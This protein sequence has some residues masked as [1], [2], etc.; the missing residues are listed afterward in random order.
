MAGGQN[1]LGQLDTVEVMN[2]ETL[3]WST[4][5]SLPYPYSYASATLCGEQ[6]YMLGGFQAGDTITK[7]V[8]T[9]SLPSLLQSCSETSSGQVWHGIADVPMYLST[10][11]AINGELVA[12]GG[13]DREQ[14]SASSIH[15]YNPTTDSR[16]FFSHTEVASR[17]LSFVA[18]LPTIE[19]M[20]VGGETDSV[21]ITDQVEIGWVVLT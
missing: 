13:C 4:A 15:K 10:C 19:I 17:H 14:N 3:V 12:V 2:I 21:D 16:D 5:A 7:S 20:V 1:Q 18:I 6:L 8:L 9:C 11:A